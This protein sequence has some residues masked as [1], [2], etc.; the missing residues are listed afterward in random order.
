V[1]HAIEIEGL[2]KRFGERVVL[3][4]LTLSIERGETVAFL[5]ASG[6]GKSTLLRC[7]GGLAKPDSGA[8]AV[9]G[10]IGFVYQEPRLFPWLSVEK[11]VAFAARSNLERER[12]NDAIELVGLA[13]AAHL[14]PKALSGGMAQRA[15]LA[16]ALVRNPQILLLDEPL[17]ALDA[18]L[19]LELQAAL[20]T[21]VQRLGATVA[22]VTHDVDEALYLAD[23]V[24]VLAGAPARVVLE[25]AV[26]SEQRRSRTA[27]LTAL[28]VALLEAL[29]VTGVAR[30]P[31]RVVQFRSA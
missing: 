31:R 19:R 30:D 9:A 22:L 26:P 5:G 6:C 4:D 27:D 1:K 25:V 7:I 20:G 11:N 16:R 13:P 2:G 21:I 14:L 18:L 3:D 23:R 15:S 12:V 17:S 10:E 8:V 29:G 28:R 24:L